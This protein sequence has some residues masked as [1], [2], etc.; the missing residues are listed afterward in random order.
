[1]SDIRWTKRQQQAIDTVDRSV[2]VSAAAGSG[3]TAVLSARCAHLIC[4]APPPFRCNVDQILVVTFTEAAAAEMRARIVKQLRSR[5]A[6]DPSDRRIRRQAALVDG[7]QISTLHAFCL[8]IIREWFHRVQVDAAAVLLDADEADLIQAEMLDRVFERQYQ[9]ESDSGRRFRDLVEQYGLGSDYGIRQCVRKTAALCDSLVDPEGWLN[10]TADA[11]DARFAELFDESLATL[12]NECARQSQHHRSIAAYIH[13]R[14]AIA[15]PLAEDLIRIADELEHSSKRSD[16]ASEAWNDIGAS[17]ADLIDKAPRQPSRL[18]DDQKQQ[19]QTAKKLYDDSKDLLKSRLTEGLALFSAA[20][21]RAGFDR[22]APFTATLVELVRAFQREYEAVKRDQGVMDFTDLERYAHR[23]LTETQDDEPQSPVAL[24]MRAK[25][26]HVLVDEYQD[27]NPLQAEILRQVSR[28]IQSDQPGDRTH[29]GNLFAVGDVKQSI[30]RFRLAEPN[31]FVH[32]QHH[33]ADPQTPARLIAMQTNFRS[34]PRILGAINAAFASLMTGQIDDVKYDE[35]ARLEPAI[36]AGDSDPLVELHIL[37]DD[38]KPI[39]DEA[40]TDAEKTS[41]FVDPDD[42][43]QWRSVEREAFLIGREIDALMKRGF[44]INDGDVAR[45]MRYRDVG[46]LLRT[47]KVVA[48][49]MANM[50]NSMGI[51]AWADTGQDL[52]DTTE[53]RDALSLLAVIDNLQQDIPLAAVL[54]SGIL[55]DRFNEDELVAIRSN[56]RGGSFARA[57][58]AFARNGPI[59]ALRARCA[60]IIDTIQ[61]YRKRSRTEPVADVLWSIYTDTSFLA[62]VSGRR[63]G[64]ERRANLLALHDWARTFSQFRRQGLSRFLRFVEQLRDRKDKSA[65]STLPDAADTVRIMSIHRSK[66]LEFPVVFVAELGR[67]FNLSDTSGRMI[68][69]RDT[70]IGLRAVDPERMIEYPTIAH[71]LCIR[72]T[73]QADLAEELRI[74][75]VAMT[76]ARQK[77]VLI[78]T[79]PN[80]SV[81]KWMIKGASAKKTNEP[82]QVSA[83]NILSGRCPLHWLLAAMGT[84]PAGLVARQSDANAGR[85][86]FVGCRHTADDIR[87]WTIDRQDAITDRPWAAAAAT[88]A[89]LPPDEPVSRDLSPVE[90]MMHRVTRAY[91]Q[92][93]V[94]SMRAAVSASEGDRLTAQYDRDESG[95]PLFAPPRSARDRDSIALRRGNAVHRVMQWV[96]LDPQ[97]QP[98]GVDA[99][100]DALVDRKLIDPSDVELIDRDAVKWFLSSELGEKARAANRYLREWMFLSSVPITAIDPAATDDESERVLVRGVVDAIIESDDTLEV[101]DF[102]TDSVSADDA[103]H[104]AVKYAMQI[105]LYARAAADALGKPVRTAHLVFLAARRIVR[106]EVRT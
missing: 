15:K 76:R 45:A 62:H 14:Y 53:I 82:A 23:L 72:R 103:E 83:L 104:R 64:R 28:E 92:L 67:K 69:E 95:Q 32:R 99:T 47:T 73:R 18:D 102:K 75:Y 98:A 84:L 9:D 56:Q 4:D 88:L 12:R 96:D 34:T 36:Q 5:A 91:P 63:N 60:R 52:F 41:Q 93:G 57:V 29:P 74:L 30:Y 85:S 2:L 59:E 20:E 25:F 43:A 77:L 55:A 97:Q 27:I 87:A 86:L 65:T 11:G 33:C 17:L 89:P 39:E 54:R 3:K 10:R 70:G 31:M 90:Q 26:V 78:G 6:L 106:V 51:P 35:S 71:D 42:P 46:V 1:M 50:L 37:D 16:T 44:Q 48:G 40:N 49:K 61:N 105:Q 19:W 38:V 80:A 13:S 7:A 81:D 100:I 66:G 101:I 21:L 58:T 24:Q 22:T 94:S 79:Q 8:S 68:L